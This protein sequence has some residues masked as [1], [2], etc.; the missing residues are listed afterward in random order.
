[1]RMSVQQAMMYRTDLVFGSITTIVYFLTQLLLI[2]FYFIAGGITKIAGYSVDD[3]Y[4]VFAFS[5][6]SIMFIFVFV[7]V[8]VRIVINQINE[9]KIDFLMMKPA[10]SRF[11][12]MFQKFEILQVFGMLVYMVIF[13][14]YL[15]RYN[16]YYLLFYDWLVLLVI[17][18]NSIILH[19]ILYWLAGLLN[20]IWPKFLA[21]WYLINNIYEIVKYP[22]KIYPGYFQEIFSI[23]FPIFL[24]VNPVF[25]VLDNSWSWNNLFQLMLVSAMFVMLFLVLFK[26]GLRRYGSAA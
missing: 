16:D 1:M 25:N 4:L 17:L 14:W 3:L 9:G 8:N 23:I 10:D 24:I 15:F 18:I 13:A 11:L 19:A 12:I 7:R 2:K 6:V 20:L 21:L 5:Q 22:K 26:Y